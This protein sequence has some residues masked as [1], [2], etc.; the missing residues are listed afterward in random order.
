MALKYGSQEAAETI[1][2][3]KE[4]DETLSKTQCRYHLDAPGVEE[5]RHYFGIVFPTMIVCILF[6]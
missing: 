4:Q 1:R 6:F 2:D 5:S 3:C